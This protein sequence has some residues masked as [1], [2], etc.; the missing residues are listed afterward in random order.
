VETDDFKSWDF[1]LGADDGRGHIAADWIVQLKVDA[2][3]ATA[4][5]STVRYLTKD[6]ALAHGEHHDAL[7]DELLRALALGS[8]AEADGEADVSAASL[9]RSPMF[10]VAA[11]EPFDATFSIVTGL[12]EAISRKRLGL[13]GHRVL[14]NSPKAIRW[15]IGLPQ[16]AET[17]HVE[18]SFWPGELRGTARVASTGQAGR[19]IA[20]H[21][22]RRFVHRAVFLIRTED[23]H[24]TYQGPE[25]LKP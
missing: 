22:L 13:V 11:P 3:T 15:G 12:D 10:R 23:E 14:D 19:R 5:V 4:T 6:D 7:R 2:A 20:A 21:A 1:V 24:A 25:E 18:I 17:D 9:K 16:N 8:Q